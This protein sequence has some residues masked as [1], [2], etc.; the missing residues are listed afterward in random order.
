M[1]VTREDGER[2][3]ENIHDAI[4]EYLEAVNESLGEADGREIEVPV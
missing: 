4:R 2:S 1:L 3:A